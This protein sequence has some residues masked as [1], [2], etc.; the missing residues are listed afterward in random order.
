MAQKNNPQKASTENPFSYIPF[1]SNDLSGREVNGGG[2]KVL[3]TVTQE[4]RERLVSNVEQ[5]VNTLSASWEF[6]PKSI[7]TVIFSLRSTGIA[8]SHRPLQLLH[9]AGLQSSGHSRIDEML[10]G[11]RENNFKKLLQVIEHRD[12]KAI[13]ANL[14][15]VSE[16]LPWTRE[17]RNPSGRTVL[18]DDG[19]ALL[20]VFRYSNHEDTVR[21]FYEIRNLLTQLNAE[22]TEIHQARSF[23]LIA[24]KDLDKISDDHLDLLLDHPGIRTFEPEPRY[25][26]FPLGSGST[27]TPQPQQQNQVIFPAPTPDLPI[28]AVFDAGVSPN[29]PALAPWIVGKD[30]YVL[31][32]E[33]QQSHGTMVASLIAGAKVLNNEHEWLPEFGS[34]IYDVQGLEETPQG[35]LMSDLAMR[36]ESAVSQRPDIKIWN[37]SLG[38]PECHDQLYSELAITL[39]RLSDDHG[40]L[41][42]ISAGN[43][44]TTPRR[45]WPNPQDLP[46]RISCPSEA[47]RAITV[48]SLNHVTAPGAMGSAGEP[49]PYSRRGPGPTF[50]PKPDVTHA[51]GGVHAPWQIGPASMNVIYP[52]NQ[53]GGTFGTSFSAPITSNIAAHTWKALEGHPE[54]SPNPQL[55]K[56][57]LIHAAQLSSP[58]FCTEERRYYGSGKPEGILETLYDSDDS[59]TLVFNASLIPGAFRWRKTPY[60]IPQ[61]LIHDGAFRG[62]VIITAAY[63][64]PLD[65]DFGSEYVRANV[66]ISFGVLEGDR[67]K[68]KVPMESEEGRSGY[69]NKQIE[70]GGKWAPVKVH[71][72]KFPKGVKGEQWALQ[73]SA[74]IRANEAPPEQGIPVYILV[75][76]RA[77]DGNTNIKGEGLNEL[78]RTN[79]LHSSIT[80]Y[81]PIQV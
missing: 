46:D 64:P 66:D 68:G 18:R 23:P 30:T 20:R 4:Y 61:S 41:F 17:S 26:S 47:V 15:A 1:S 65:A 52:N 54:L 27:N 48:A 7:A 58:D 74:S 76:L 16:I 59:F 44:T 77:I 35:G 79:W 37:L 73:A 57:L 80:S 53:I 24:I 3:T 31:P 69:E 51:G 28:V 50:S 40:V 38:G 72:K 13:Q 10:V 71:R 6:F 5:A 67:I 21:N 25:Q 49:A 60:P 43:Y 12:V 56:A 78:A 81:V 14:S 75:T 29:V 39:D 9:E 11:G 36:I 32:P 70:F 42:V 22:F 63:A 55:V 8:K 19:N 45:N 34:L 33:T 2:A 62:E